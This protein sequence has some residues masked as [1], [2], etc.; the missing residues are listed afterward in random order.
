LQP[1]KV[2]INQNKIK[3]KHQ[4]LLFLSR[5]TRKLLLV[6]LTAL[7]QSSLMGQTLSYNFEE[8]TGTFKNEGSL[9]SDFDLDGPFSVVGAEKSGVGG[10]GRAL[11]LSSSPEMGGANGLQLNIV[12]KMAFPAQKAISVT[13]WFQTPTGSPIY[14]E[15]NVTVFIRASGREPYSGFMVASASDGRLNMFIGSGETF[16]NLS[17]E[18]GAF[19]EEGKWV[20]FAATWDGETG[21]WAWYVGSENAKIRQAGTGVN[22]ATMIDGPAGVL[23][24][25]RSNS[26]SGAFKGLLDRLQIYDRALLQDEVEKIRSSQAPYR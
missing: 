14:A 21:N 26:G 9:G 2:S 20:F 3:M 18:K 12:S 4:P 17:S 5:L 1:K 24:V 13:G 8:N 23:R 6:A 10:Q 19:A 22:P 11:D 7:V 25:G 16:L 15:K